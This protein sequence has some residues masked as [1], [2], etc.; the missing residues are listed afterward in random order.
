MGHSHMNNNGA[1]DIIINCSPAVPLV[2]NVI[3]VARRPASLSVI[4]C[5]LMENNSQ[6]IWVGIEA[7][8][9]RCVFDDDNNDADKLITTDE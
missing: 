4:E 2:I 8:C 1:Y 5:Y 6:S 3:I 9:F 7:K